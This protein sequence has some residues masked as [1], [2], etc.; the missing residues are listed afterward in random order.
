MF[1][2]RWE[3]SMSQS[4]VEEITPPSNPVAD[5]AAP[6]PAALTPRRVAFFALVVAVV[7]FNI[8]ACQ[9]VLGNIA[10]D[11]GLA[12]S[13][14]SLV[15]T[16]TMLGYALG[17]LLI[18]PLADVIENRRLVITMALTCV[19]ALFAA[20]A[21]KTALPFLIL[22]FVIGAAA[23]LIQVLVPLVGVLTPAVHR[24]RVLGNVMSGLMLGIMI[25]RP[26][27]SL[28][29]EYFGWRALYASSALVLGLVVIPL[30][31]LLPSRQPQSPVAYK[32]AVS[33][34]LTLLRDEP[35]L[36][37]RALTA[38]LVMGAFNA[39]WSAVAPRLAESPFHLSATGIALFALA[40]TAG[41][42]AAPITGRLGD[43]GLTRVAT[44]ASDA[45]IVVA[46]FVALLAGSGI[47]GSSTLALVMLVASAV[48]LDSG[49]VGDQTLGRRA[50]NLLDSSAIGRRNGLF[51]GIFF[52]GGA[53]GS[54][55]VGP[56]SAFAGWAGVCLT[57]AAFG[58]A[59][60]VVSACTAKNA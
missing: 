16:A 11:L 44:L 2:A 47:F 35:T 51:V 50:I 9:V 27:A 26:T 20:A 24:G 6:A 23:S 58:V 30:R 54:A 28:V 19:G 46:L 53:A 29:N 14:A 8:F 57:A 42:I 10:K 34:L 13:H 31:M 45:I 3:S 39:F 17:L 22:C 43:R 37:S 55:L 1:D 36:R 25:S 4:V 15:S 12:W 48:L 33:S 5:R 60:L 41:A 59:A 40:G 32:K 56:V 21:V 7:I 52:I 38:A 49:T 18:V